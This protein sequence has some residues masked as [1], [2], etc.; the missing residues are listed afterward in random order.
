MARNMD[1]NCLCHGHREEGNYIGDVYFSC[2]N[3]YS[4]NHMNNLPRDP[5]RLTKQAQAKKAPRKPRAEKPKAEGSFVKAAAAVIMENIALA[6][7]MSKPKFVEPHV[8]G[9]VP[10]NDGELQAAVNIHKED[11]M[12]Q[13]DA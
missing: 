8:A 11:A 2:K 12:S 4:A 3:C 7:E 1:C 6:A 5:E 10:E 9:K 13:R